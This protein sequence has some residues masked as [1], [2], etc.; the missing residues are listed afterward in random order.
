MDSPVILMCVIGGMHV[1][2]VGVDLSHH[3]L[4][5]PDQARIGMDLG[6]DEVGEDE[7]CGHGRGG[8]PGLA[9]PL[10]SC[11]SHAATA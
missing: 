10:V 2:G 6:I 5:H 11:S 8:G 1:D 7:L 3:V 9:T 4:D